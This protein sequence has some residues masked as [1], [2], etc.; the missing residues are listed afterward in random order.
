MVR[1]LVQHR[2]GELVHPIGDG[3]LRHHRRAGPGNEG[4]DAVVDLRVHMI[5]PARQHN[6]AAALRP[7]LFDDALAL[8]PNQGHV[9]G[10]LGIGR[11][12]GLLHL[13]LRDVREEAAQDIMDLLRE[14]LG[15][16]EAHIV[17]DELDILDFR[18]VSGNDLRV[19]GH[20]RA[21]V[22]VLAQALVDVVG[23]AGVEDGV[24]SQLGEEL[25]VAVGQLGREAGSVAGDGPLPFQIQIPAGEGAVIDREAQLREESVPEGQQLPHIQTQGDADLAPLAGNGLVA[26]NQFPL[27]GIQ[28]PLAGVRLAGDGSVAAVAAD[29]GIAVGEG[30]DGELAVV[31]AASADLA[32]GLLVEGRQGL[33]VQQGTGLAAG[34]LAPAIQGRT[35]GA[36]EARDVGADDLHTHLLLKGPEDGFVVER[37]ALDHDVPAQLLG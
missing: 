20:H 7:G 32:A 6:D 11:V 17:V 24:Q 10:V 34:R 1:P 15:P 5:G 8:F 31:A 9:V 14:V 4:V 25:D 16:V 21:V 12:S 29:E 36:H 2:S 33:P 37:A 19:V 23:H 18:A 30:I 13:V 26:Q 22:V 35:V 27:V 3:V 28:V